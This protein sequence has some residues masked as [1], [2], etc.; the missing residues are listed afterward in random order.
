MGY[1]ASTYTYSPLGQQLL[2]GQAASPECEI[3][4]RQNG[5]DTAQ[6]E[7]LQL[8]STS[9]SVTMTKDGA[10]YTFSPTG[11]SASLA[12]AD[13]AADINAHAVVSGWVT[14]S[15]S[16]D[17]VTAT[18]REPGTG[19]DVTYSG[20]SNI[21]LAETTAA[22]N[23]ATLAIGVGVMEGSTAGRLSTLAGS[24]EVYHVT[25]TAV[26]SVLYTAT[27]QEILADGTPGRGYDLPYTADGS[28]TVQEIVEGWAAVATA[29]LPAALAVATEDNTKLI[30]TGAGVG[31]RISV[32]AGAAGGT[33]VVT[34]S[35]ATAGGLTRPFL[36]WTLRDNARTLDI[37]SPDADPTYAAYEQTSICTR[38]PIAVKVDGTVSI[39]G[40]VYARVTASGSEVVGRARGDTDSGDA[41]PAPGWRF[42][43][44]GVSD[45]VVIIDRF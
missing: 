10:S 30:V 7:T 6:V 17:T 25:P 3:K 9:G 12:A 45:D 29:L 32:S 43:G 1:Q 2:N 42:K 16:T 22:A 20:A 36:G 37:N 26:N 13:L 28:A 21:T 11:A 35:R 39:G 44:A 40:Q 23:G 5:A 27:V 4:H 38:G 24:S 15:V 19:G 34:V 8:T 14:C 31:I 18:A 41:V 33:A